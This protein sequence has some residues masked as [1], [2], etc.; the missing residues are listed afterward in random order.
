M[1]NAQRVAPDMSEPSVKDRSA[2]TFDPGP[3]RSHGFE[4][5][6]DRLRRAFT[7]KGYATAEDF[8][9]A[10]GV[11]PGTLRMQLNRGKIPRD[12]ALR[13]AGFLQKSIAWLL[14]GRQGRDDVPAA[15]IAGGTLDREALRLAIS[16]AEVLAQHHPLTD[17]QR[18]DL[19][20]DLTPVLRDRLAQL[21]PS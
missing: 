14:T 17:D 6:A 12:A 4:T 13:Y 16:A 2:G 5:P 9:A 11:K 1:L 8:A 7:E 3:D 19:I 20:A 18:A 21:R 15:P 10:V